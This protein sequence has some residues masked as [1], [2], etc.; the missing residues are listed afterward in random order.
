MRSKTA[1]MTI[2]G[3]LALKASAQGQSSSRAG[4]RERIYGLPVDLTARY[5]RYS[6]GRPHRKCSNIRA[7]NTVSTARA[8]NRFIWRVAPTRPDRCACARGRHSRRASYVGTR[9]HDRPQ[10]VDDRLRRCRAQG[11]VRSR[12]Q[13]C[14][15]YSRGRLSRCRSAHADQTGLSS[16]FLDNPDLDDIRFRDRIGIDGAQRIVLDNSKGMSTG[17]RCLLTGAPES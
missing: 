7:E 4:A 2:L 9:Y 13:R 1:I 10:H 12:G 14:A 3:L 16:L 11:I 8:S 5:D 15:L 17:S 6:V